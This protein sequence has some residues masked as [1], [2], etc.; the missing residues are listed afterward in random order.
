[1]LYAAAIRDEFV[2]IDDNATLHSAQVTNRYPEGNGIE[3]MEQPTSRPLTSPIENLC[4]DIKSEADKKLK[5]TSLQDLRR[6][7]QRA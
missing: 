5:N 2:F 6:I 1:M 7:L 4:D 3:P